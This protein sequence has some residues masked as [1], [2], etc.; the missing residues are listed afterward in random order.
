[1]GEKAYYITTPIYYV[2]DVPHIGNAYTT[3]VSDVLARHQRQRGRKV[4]FA[5]GTDEN[6]IKVAEAAQQAGMPPKEF[7]DKLAAAFVDVWE[8]L[9]IKYDAFIR[10]TEPRHVAVVQRAFEI[11][12]DRGDVY[13]G[14]YEGW[15]CVSDET[16]FR[17]SE[18][19]D[20]KCPNA[21]CRK[22][23][24]WV[25]E[26]NYYF[27]LSAY[28]DRLLEHIERNPDFLQPEFRKNE[29]VSFI[30][31]GLQDISITRANRGW[32][33]PVP[34]EPD[35][36]IYVWFDALLNYITIAGWESP[37]FD[38][39]WPAD[40]QL[41]G[42]DIFVR[43][44]CTF[45]P[46]MLMGLGVELPKVLFGH[47]WWSIEGEKISKSKGNAISPAALAA[48]LAAMSGATNGVA[49][50][51]I[52]YFVMREAPFGVDADFSRD[53]LKNRFN[54]DLA[55][56]LGNLLNRTL[57][58]LD[59]YMDRVIPE[60]VGVALD[61]RS[62]AEATHKEVES[63]FD[64]FQFSRALE[65]IWQLVGAGNRYLE[66]QAPWRLHKEGKKAELAT[67]L[68]STL[69]T[70]RMVTVMIAPFMPEAAREMWRQLGIPEP[71]EE[72]TWADAGAWGR[73]APGTRA[74]AAEPIFPRIEDKPRKEGRVEEQKPEPQEHLTHDEF[75]KM[76]LRIAEIVAA[77]RHPNAD[78]LLKL[79]V[80]LGDERRT[81]VAGIAQWYEPDALV[82]KKIVL[83]ANLAPATIRGVQSQGMLLAAD[84]DGQAVI[85]TPDSDVP[86]G[87]K[88]R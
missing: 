52:R 5:T 65:A 18:V 88:I 33:I 82:G 25:Q 78:K 2:T 32:G 58:M 3:I 76:E 69:E 46:A 53:S 73:L 6:A 67:V 54:S 43:F 64:E 62:I 39:I 26:E 79:T 9:H 4:V 12:R 61:L 86:S 29:V 75:K 10:T 24:Q 85:L 14:V 63:A 50:D 57:S 17:E 30:K 51:V 40:I 45:W 8:S 15:Y 60:P 7:V 49:I 41:M 20:G 72:Q 34:G 83:L 38:E 59:R 21:E 84:V 47:G 87:A 23:V 80:S 36:V 27:K 48:D 71:L 44:H 22:P 37:G 66:D 35:K 11:L 74:G 13:K 31:Q 19:V 68:Y 16:F 28:Q 55:N 81:I 70:A 1:M 77:E 42:K 56:D